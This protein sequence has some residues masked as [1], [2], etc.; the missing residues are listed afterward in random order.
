MRGSHGRVER[1]SPYA[2]V[3]IADGVHEGNTGPLPAT[4]VH[5]A[6]LEACGGTDGERGRRRGRRRQ[7]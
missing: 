1:G 4:A 7:R 3:L 5:D 2:P 6:I